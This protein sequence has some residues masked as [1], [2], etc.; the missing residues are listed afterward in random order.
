MKFAETRLRGAW[1]I[2]PDRQMDRRGFFAR[3]YCAREFESQK[4]ISSFVQCNVSYNQLRGT[5]RGM[6]FQSPPNTEAK[7]VRC[8]RGSIYDVIVDLRPS[9][10]TFGEYFAAEISSEN[11]LSLYIPEGFA[12]G[13][14]TLEDRTE[15]FYQMTNYYVP[16]S[17]AGLSFDD[18]EIGIRWPLPVS[19]ISDKDLNWPRMS[20]WRNPFGERSH[21]P[22]EFLPGTRTS[23][24]Q[25]TS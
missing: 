11:G 23:R 16:E 24:P 8:S 13:F 18:P 4:L 12:H 19:A 6:H 7:L 2:I 22:E 15:V 14:Q 21:E 1:V 25:R 3:T 10:S 5:L 17:A 9:S 20:R